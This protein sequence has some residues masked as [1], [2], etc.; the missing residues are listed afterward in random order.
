MII[1]R[2]LKPRINVD[3]TPLIDVVFQL[4]IFFMISS[5]FKTAPGIDLTLPDS[6]SAE[7]IAVAEL[8]V[9]A[10]SETEVYVNKVLTTALGA[11]AVIQS[12][13][14][15]RNVSEVQATLEAGANAPYQLVVD[16]LDA[17]RQN[18]VM[19]VGLATNRK[20]QG[21]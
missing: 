13:L 2:R 11:A 3:L 21:P 10:V 16:L 15:G 14:Q 18:G 1:D 6:G 7:V 19:A 20:D 12:E 17:L 8:S 5:T 4:V 9:T